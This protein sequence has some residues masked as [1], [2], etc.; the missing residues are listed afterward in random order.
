MLAWYEL[1]KLLTTP[2]IIVFVLLCIAYNSVIV[3]VSEHVRLSEVRTDAA[4]LTDIFDGFD[5]VDI[6]AG[7][8]VTRHELSGKYEQ[9]V[10]EKYE[11]LQAVVEKKAA[12]DE[13]LSPYFGDWTQPMHKLLFQKLLGAIIAQCGLLALFASLIS[14]GYENVRATE[15]IVYCS[16]SGRQRILR[17]KF[18]ASLIAGGLLFL[19]LM[20]VSLALFFFRFDW[21]MVWDDH[22]SSLYNRAVDEIAKP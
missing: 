21:T 5:A 10:R 1:K 22:V 3:F 9:N 6:I 13:S 12:S 7:R 2:T 15:G 8:Y 11:K 19:L 16:K 14:T 17:A 4:A 20:S 18:V